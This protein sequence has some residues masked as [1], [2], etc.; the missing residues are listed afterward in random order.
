[1]WGK[2]PHKSE[3]T[4]CKTFVVGVLLAFEIAVLCCLP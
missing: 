4:T 2:D 1:L 3:C